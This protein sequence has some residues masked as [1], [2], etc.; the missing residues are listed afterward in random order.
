M[1]PHQDNACKRHL[2]LASVVVFALIMQASVRASP[3]ITV[4]W[5]CAGEPVDPDHYHVDYTNPSYPDVELKSECLSWKIKSVDNGNPG[6]IGEIP[7]TDAYNY[8]LEITDGS[9]GPGARDVQKID[10]NPSDAAKYSL[11]NGGQISGDLTGDLFVQE[12]SDESGGSV[13]FTV[14]GNVEDDITA[15]TIASLS[16]GGNL[17]GNVSVDD[18]SGTMSVTG[19]FL[20]VSHGFTAD[21]ISGSLSIGG[22]AYGVLDLAEFTGSLSVAGD[23]DFEWLIIGGSGSGD[24][25]GGA[26]SGSVTLAAGDGNA[27]SGTATFS[28]VASG[29]VVQTWL[30]S[31]SGTIHV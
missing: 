2:A 7:A 14:D 13:S 18:V 1:K 24:I 15:A 27:Y 9:S 12:S 20:T 5:D 21:D 16:I 3:T 22:N 8:G 30:A 19:D 10:L 31:V 28:S 25:T 29:A 26:V 23:V 11:I 17:S 6:D 4:T